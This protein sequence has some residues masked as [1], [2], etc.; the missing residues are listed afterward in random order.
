[1]IENYCVTIFC[2]KESVME[3][4]EYLHS[5]DY[6]FASKED[7]QIFYDKVADDFGTESLGLYT[8]S[9]SWSPEEA[10]NNLKTRLSGGEFRMETNV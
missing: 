5:I 3:P 6:R 8:D 9:K 7:A 2:Y 1:M 10:Y 4:G